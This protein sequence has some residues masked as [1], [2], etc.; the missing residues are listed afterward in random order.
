MT[1]RR[2]HG[3]DEAV[4]V[5]KQR[6]TSSAPKPQALKLTTLMRPNQSRPHRGILQ[7]VVVCCITLWY[8]YEVIIR[9]TR[10]TCRLPIYAYIYIY[11][12]IH[13]CIYI[14]IYVYIYI[15]ICVSI[16]LSLYIYIYIYIYIPTLASDRPTGPRGAVVWWEKWYI[17]SYV[18]K[19][20]CNIK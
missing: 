5:D 3:T 8:G 2:T 1:R 9:A 12:Y 20:S 17:I 18:Q 7:K 10:Q 6:Q 13:V 14:Y 4:F 11:T 15:Y 16:S 19:W